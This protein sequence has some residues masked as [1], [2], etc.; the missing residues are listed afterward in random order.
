MGQ[1]RRRAPVKCGIYPEIGV[2]RFVLVFVA[3][4]LLSGNVA[5]AEEETQ[6]PIPRDRATGLFRYLGVVTV[7]GV[8]PDDLYARAKGWVAT[9]YKSAHHV[10]QLDEPGVRL[11]VKGKMKLTWATFSTVYV[12]HVVTIEVRNGGYRYTVGGL[13]VEFASKYSKPPTP[14]ERR[15]V[16]EPG[17]EKMLHKIGAKIDSMIDSLRLAMH[18]PS[19][20]EW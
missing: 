12:D 4:G 13:V 18:E 9:E 10:I 15:D 2:K 17:R 3:L 14:L 16:L 7:E 20:D 5:G 11:I 19:I 8:A 6:E 1:S